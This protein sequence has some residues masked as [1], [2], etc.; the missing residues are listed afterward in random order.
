MRTPVARSSSTVSFAF[1]EPMKSYLVIFMIL[2]TLGCASA[3]ESA[4]E[5]VTLLQVLA[6]PEK[7]DGKEILII[8]YL[9][10]EFEGDCLYLHKEDYDHAI[11]GNHIWVDVTARMEKRKRQLNDK[12][13][14]IRGI[15]E[16]KAHGHLGLSSGTLKD[17]TRCD[18]W[19]EPKKPRNRG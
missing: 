5:V 2:L 7:Y 8:G 19:S 1:D 16:A 3:A 15:F 17:I 4:S 14:I 13:V 6:R 9:H 18:V 12:Y 11:I 10:L